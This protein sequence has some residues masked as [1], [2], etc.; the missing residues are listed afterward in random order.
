MRWRKCEVRTRNGLQCLL[1]EVT[2]YREAVQ[3]TANAVTVQ[4]L[5]AALLKI[6]SILFLFNCT[7]HPSK[8]P[9]LVPFF[10]SLLPFPLSRF[11]TSYCTVLYCTLHLWIVHSPKVHLCG[12]VSRAAE[13]ECRSVTFFTMLSFSPC[14]WGVW[15]PLH[16]EDG[17]RHG[18]WRHCSYAGRHLVTAGVSQS[19]SQP[20]KINFQ[21]SRKFNLIS[22][23]FHYR[24][25]RWLEIGA[26]SVE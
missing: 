14:E 26:S 8:K 25:S 18:A 15:D 3:K 21:S 2:T 11:F 9:S 10:P 16:C 20:V 23:R 4:P 24:L 12:R 5:R 7:L 1:Y 22:N 19:V 6:S 17:C 13:S